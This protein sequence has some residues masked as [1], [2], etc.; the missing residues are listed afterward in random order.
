[1]EQPQQPAS[2]T[3]GASQPHPV[4]EKKKKHVSLSAPFNPEEITPA[5]PP[6][7]TD[8]QN[9]EVEKIKVVSLPP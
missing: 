7:A 8:G 2:T 6:A 5:A 1:M 9:P 4:P 3:N